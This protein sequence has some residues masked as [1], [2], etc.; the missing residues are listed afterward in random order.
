MKILDLTTDC[1]FLKAPPDLVQVV[2]CQTGRAVMHSGCPKQAPRSMILR[3]VLELL[4]AR[5]YDWIIVPPSHVRWT[6]GNSVVKRIIKKMMGWLIDH[7]RVAF[8]MRN[9]IFG[10]RA[11]FAV[12]DY[13]DLFQ[14]SEFAL[15]CIEPV[16][17]FQLNVPRKL[18][19]QRI[20]PAG[21]LIHY[22]PT[23]IQDELI[24]S[25]QSQRH[26]EGGHDVFVAGTYHNEQR[27]KQLDATRLLTNRGW[28]VF[29]LGERSFGK[30][31]AGILDSK[32][33][34]AGKG[35]AYHCFRPL[36]A[37]AAGAA[38]VTHESEEGAYH[39][40]ING[41]N[42]FLYDPLLQP[43]EIAD[44]FEYI[45]GQP[46]QVAKVVAGAREL[47]NNRHRASV[48]SKNLLGILAS[49]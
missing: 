48:L 25:L 36:E 5:R 24:D 7:P 1:L 20:G 18:V 4:R 38:P 23:V 12:I 22:L 19:G 8:F 31:T 33:C 32:L 45:L 39:E 30:F 26:A 2:H 46:S 9:A 44:Y 13:S 21:T 47:L 35:L 40:Y 29:E 28:K 11:R 10:K 3:L 42:C 6:I 15:N 17:Y 27:V 49:S 41:E 34:M 14:P 37:A 43:K 16:H